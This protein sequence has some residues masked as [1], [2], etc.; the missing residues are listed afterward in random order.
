MVRLNSVVR[1]V[2]L[3]VP[4]LSIGGIFLPLSARAL[5]F[6]LNSDDP[7]LLWNQATLQ[8]IKNTTFGPTPASRSLGIVHTSIFDAWS[9]FD[10]VAISTQASSRYQVSNDFAT[11]ANKKEAISYAAYT[12]LVDLFP[13]QKAIFD[14]L[15]IQQGYD[16]TNL[17]T[18]R[19]TA[20]GVGNFAAI[21]LINYRRQDG[22]NQIN[23]YADTTGYQP[24]NTWDKINDPNRWQPIS[25]DNGVTIQKF[26]TPQWGDVTPFALNSGSEFLPDAPALFGTEEYIDQA[27]EVIKIRAGLTDE[28][29]TIT[30]YW[31]AGPGTELPPGQWNQIGEYVSIRDGL[32]LDENVQLFFALGNSVMDAG[33][34][35]WDAKVEY[36]YIRPISA[37]RYLASQGL[38]PEDGTYVRTNSETGKQEINIGSEWVDGTQWLPYQKATFITPPFAE[39][40]SGHSTFSA[41]AAEI[42]KRFSGSD[43]FGGCAT[44]P[45]GSSQFESGTP[46]TDIELCWDTFTDAAREAGQSRLFGGIHFANGNKGGKILGRKVG[47]A[48]WDTAQF[49]IN[50]GKK[51][52]EPSSWLAFSFVAWLG[53]KSRQGT[54]TVSKRID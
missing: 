24:V 8:A 17:S 42:L 7:V 25:L 39:H 21:E 28:E 46:A 54:R 40:V 1:L 5:D 50:G 51:T 53:A 3:C 33:I 18:D 49:Y 29:K 11:E 4:L 6:T 12:A 16:P 14:N 44:V 10:P 47:N 9:A 23:G 34:A 31:S 19:N 13:T 38:L 35:T 22:S 27:V 43:T 32:S 2:R 41:S 48:V 36:D 20:A 26:L 15:M 52:P 30:E 45:A 37:I